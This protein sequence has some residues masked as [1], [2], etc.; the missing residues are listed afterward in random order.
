MFPKDIIQQGNANVKAVDAGPISTIQVEVKVIHESS[1][2]RLI[3]VGY[4]SR[5]PIEVVQAHQQEKQ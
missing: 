5:S 4:C 1:P 2:L 3:Q